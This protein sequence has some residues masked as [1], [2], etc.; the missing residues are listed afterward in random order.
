VKRIDRE[1]LEQHRDRL[2]WRKPSLRVTTME[3]ALEFV[4]TV[5]L[6]FAF[7]SRRSELPCLW[8]A[9][10]GERDPK[11]PHHTHHDPAI[12]LVWT[13]KDVLPAERK[14]YYGKALKKRPTMIS[15]SLF[16]YFFSAAGHPD[17]QVYLQSFG[18]E[19]MTPM[20]RRV[21][22][23]LL[24]SPP[25]PT[26]ILKDQAGGSGSRRRAEFDRAMAELQGLLLVCKV[27]E[28]YDPF[29]FVWGRVD[30]WLER[31]VEKARKISVQE[32]Q[33]EVLRRY[34]DRVIA[35]R[36]AAVCRLFPWPEKALTER[37]DELLDQKI[38][39]D[40]VRVDDQSGWLLNSGYPEL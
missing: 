12:G 9:A 11:M 5:H 8:H 37:L 3:D 1:T 21:L 26:R 39:T 4:E 31:H 24:D 13:A 6:A 32:G 2:Y 17:P 14:I 35:A 18:A 20:A 38:L 16:P 22:E 19:G 7:Q 36:R 28:T 23:V 27:A 25:L 10:C 40:T 33:R 34:F 30:R 29:T 15:L